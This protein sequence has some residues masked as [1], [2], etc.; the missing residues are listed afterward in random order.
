VYQATR[1]QG[2]VGLPIRE[3]HAWT[4]PVEVHSKPTNFTIEFVT[5]AAALLA[6]RIALHQAINHRSG[7]LRESYRFAKDYLC[8]CLTIET[9]VHDLVKHRG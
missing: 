1:W 9:P 2:K 3:R 8:D 4:T 7:N 6:S 5:A